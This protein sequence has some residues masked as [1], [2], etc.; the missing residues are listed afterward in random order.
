MEKFIAVSYILFWGHFMYRKVRFGLLV[1]LVV[2]FLIFASSGS[3]IGTDSDTSF[4]DFENCECSQVYGTISENESYLQEEPYMD[5][6]NDLPIEW[7]WRDVDGQDWTTPIKNQLQDVCGSCWA[8]GALGGLEAMIKIWENDSGLEVDLSE[9]YMLSCS[10]GDCGGWFWIAT[11]NWIK[12]NGAI[13]EACLPYMADDTIPCDAKCPEWGE[14]IIGID[15]YIP[16]FQNISMIQSALVTYGPLPATMDVYEDF[17]PNFQGGV[18]Q[19]SWGGFVF[20]HCI[21]IVGYNDSWGGP[22]EGYWIVKN[23]WGTD[24]GEDGWFRIAYGECDIERNVYYYL[25]PNFAEVKPA[26]PSGTVNG[27]PWREYS[28]TSSAFDPDGDM[29]KYCFD[30]GEGNTSWSDYVD[31]GQPV[32]MNYT[33]KEKGDY[34][35]KVKVRDEHGLDSP[36]S[37]PLPVSMPLN[38]NVAERIFSSGILERFIQF[39]SLGDQLFLIN[40]T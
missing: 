11:L 35:V 22:D 23:S 14:Q 17:Y 7:D 19:Y 4:P 29:I 18:Y 5:I 6:L 31:S 37:D 13:S 3:I 33:W 38:F 25:G 32:S 1:S 2:C 16:V 12:E 30:W 28:Y 27:R 15:S 21:T 20:G 34:Q 9:Q 24:W 10:P 39:F 26:T 8:F 40:R 36:W